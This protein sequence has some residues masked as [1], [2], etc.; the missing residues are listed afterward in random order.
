[1]GDFMSRN[2]TVTYYKRAV[3]GKEKTEWAKTK[4]KAHSK[5]KQKGWDK[6]DYQIESKREEEFHTFGKPNL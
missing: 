1:M 5:A 4:E 2:H 6:K 3:K